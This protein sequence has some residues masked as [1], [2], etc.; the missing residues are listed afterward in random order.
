MPLDPGQPDRNGTFP[1]STTDSKG[2]TCQAKMSNAG[3]A[4]FCADTAGTPIASQSMAV[5]SPQSSGLP[6]GQ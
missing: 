4:A 2:A 1:G 5:P 3:T 6:E